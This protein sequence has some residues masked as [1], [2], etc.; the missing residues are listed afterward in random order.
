MN[1]IV[2]PVDNTTTSTPQNKSILDYLNKYYISFILFIVTIISFI[3]F[4]YMLIKTP[5]SVNMD[6]IQR[7]LNI[8]QILKK[9]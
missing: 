3:E 5:D 2:M 7:L 9:N 4:F 1:S 6:S 8:S